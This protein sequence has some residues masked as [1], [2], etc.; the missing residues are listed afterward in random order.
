MAVLDDEQL[1]FGTL[2]L[3]ATSG[4]ADYRPDAGTRAK[5]AYDAVTAKFPADP[6]LAAALTHVREV[7]MKIQND[8]LGTDDYN[9]P[10]D[11]GFAA[12]QSLID[13]GA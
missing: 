2:L 13:A 6:Q 3:S 12:A 10:E 1:V 7:A 11:C 8:D 9:T 4:W 5:T